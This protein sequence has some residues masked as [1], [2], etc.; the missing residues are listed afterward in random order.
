MPIITV[1][2]LAGR[3]SAQKGLF[4]ERIAHATVATLGVPEDAVRIVL[5]EIA[6]EDW[7]VGPRTMADLRSADAA[8]LPPG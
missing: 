3:T 2:M 8:D 6:P 1:Q 4:I 5:N 7:G